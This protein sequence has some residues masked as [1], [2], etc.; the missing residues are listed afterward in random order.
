MYGLRELARG[1][2]DATDLAEVKKSIGSAPR[3]C[4]TWKGRHT[5][6]AYA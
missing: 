4:K 6:D 2:N 5:F 1:P 3:G